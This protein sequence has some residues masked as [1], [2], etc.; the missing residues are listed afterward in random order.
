MI[1][2]HVHGNLARID[3]FGVF[4]KWSVGG[5]GEQEVVWL[6]G[7]EIMELLIVTGVTKLEKTNYAYQKYRSQMCRV[8]LLN[9]QCVQL[10]RIENESDPS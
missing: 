7:N 8:R 4:Q 9:S 6:C 1:G 5:R 10:C 2:F 3:G